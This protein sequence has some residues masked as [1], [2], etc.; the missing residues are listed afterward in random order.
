[1]ENYLQIDFESAKESLKKLLK[2]S[3]TFRDYNYEGANITMLIELMSYVTELSTYYN[4]KLA[5]NIFPESAEI[6]ETMHSI[7]NIRGY[8][9]KGY[10]APHLD[11]EIKIGITEQNVIPI[12]SPGDTIHIPAWYTI[13]TQDGISYTTTED[14]YITIPDISDSEYIF[15]ITLKQGTPKYYEYQGPDVINNRI[16]LNNE[17]FDH[18]I[19]PYDANPS[20]AVYV[21]GELWERVANFEDHISLLNSN[22]NVY[23]LEY[24][25]YQRYNIVFSPTHN[26]PNKQMDRITVIANITK[27]ID[28]M[29]K[30]F[31]IN[32]EGVNDIQNI[33]TYDN[34]T[35]RAKMME[36]PFMWNATKEFN[37]QEDF[38]EI[39]NR[40]ASYNGASPETLEDIN[41]NSKN[42]MWTQFRNVSNVDYKEHIEQ[43]PNVTKGN[44]W[45][46][47]EQGLGNLNYYNK[48]YLSVIPSKWGDSTINIEYLL[49]ERED[50]NLSEWVFIPKQDLYIEGNADFKQSLYTHLER[51]KY[52]N[53]Y[54]VFTLPELVWFAFDIGI[55]TKR[56]FN[57]E[58]V[59]KE[60]KDKLK[61]YFKESNRNFNEVIDFK[62]IHKFILDTNKWDGENSFPLIKGIQNLIFRDALVY[63]PTIY[64]D[65]P[66]TIYN[67]NSTK[68]PRYTVDEYMVDFDNILRP[69][70]IGY[71]QF[72]MLAAENCLFV[73]E[74]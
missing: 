61:F 13:E 69:I 31:I 28:G 18:D 34:S 55:K 60:V 11:L 20:I 22:D 24:D 52:L 36:M 6:Y 46:E 10:I 8:Y 14:H 54:E 48:V 71:N 1:M 23:M 2:N 4:N 50:V 26:L 38:Y 32:N 30:S 70:K 45:G 66:D 7:A 33:I 12:S 47:K 67:F 62:D 58:T 42:L 51:R 15:E 17:R 53:T 73:N 21:N 39:T 65:T 5:K 41:Y 40:I 74:G 35:N 29:V 44:I 57:Y 43:H 37:L 3:N 59:K 49:W 56:G 68:Y 63:T 27:G 16:L 25:K 72:P 9:P 19:Y 64:P